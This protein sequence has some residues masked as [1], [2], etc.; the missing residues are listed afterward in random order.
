MTDLIRHVPGDVPWMTA[1]AELSALGER[2]LM[3]WTLC[4]FVT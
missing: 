3:Q 1:H 4:S 2:M